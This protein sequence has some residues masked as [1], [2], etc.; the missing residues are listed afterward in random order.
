MSERVYACGKVEPNNEY[1]EKIFKMIIERTLYEKETS[2]EPEYKCFCVNLANKVRKELKL[3]NKIIAFAHN[4][5]LTDP[6]IIIFDREPDFKSYTP[7]MDEE[8]K[9]PYILI[10]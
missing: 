5:D 1:T 3:P 6:C 4:K 8:K 9:V 2:P 10:D 7:I